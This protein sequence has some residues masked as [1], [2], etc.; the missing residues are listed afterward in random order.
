MGLSLSQ[1]NTFLKSYASYASH[2]SYTSY[3]SYTS[4]LTPTPFRNLTDVTLA[5]EEINSMLTD[6]AFRGNVAM[7]VSQPGY[8]IAEER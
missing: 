3:T 7:Q 1:S 5:D 4:Y 6:R 8:L 2:A